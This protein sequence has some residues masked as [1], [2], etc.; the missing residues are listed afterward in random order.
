VLAP[1]A[2]ASDVLPNLH[3]LCF[4]PR[5][6]S[7]LTH[8]SAL[9]CTRPHPWTIL[10]TKSGGPLSGGAEPR[11]ASSACITWRVREPDQEL[12]LPLKDIQGHRNLIIARVVSYCGKVRYL[13]VY[14]GRFES[15]AVI[16]LLHSTVS[17]TATRKACA[18]LLFTSFYSSSN[19]ADASKVAYS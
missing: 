3:L 19:I 5:Y 6:L 12:H 9:L 11:H 10:D 7:S 1:T 4:T 8:V 16:C 2:V 14:C 15:H 13:V 18:F 17:L